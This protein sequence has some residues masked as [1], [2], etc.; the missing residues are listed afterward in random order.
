M[1]GWGRHV[2]GAAA[3]SYIALDYLRE[4]NPTLH[5]VSQPLLWGALAAAA[6]LRAPWYGHWPLELRAA[7]AFLACL[8]FMLCALCI[9][10]ISVQFVT[11]VLGLSWHWSTPPLPDTGQW[12]LLA[13]NE[14]L[15]AP[16]VYFLRAHLVILNHYLML[17]LM[18]AFSVVFDV[19]KA[20]GLGLGSRYMFTMAIGRL[21]RV[22]TFVATILPSAR[23]WCA[24]ARFRVPEYPHPWAQK[25][26]TPYAN[27]PNKIKALLRQDM[28]D[29]PLAEYP[30]EY[31][32]NW[33]F[34]Q[35]LVDFLRPIEPSGAEESWFHTL[36]RA[37]GG[38]ND[39]IFSGHILVSV[40]TAMAWTEANP[41]WTSWFVWICVLHSAQREIR[42][43]HHY[44]VDVV[45]GIYMGILLWRITGF[46]WSRKDKRKELKASCFLKVEGKFL[47]AAKD[48]DVERIRALL[49]ELE[50]AGKE[51]RVSRLALAV[52]GVV[53][54]TLSLSLGLLAFVWTVDG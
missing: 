13:F 54:I 44:S 36:K 32:P 16:L 10:A 4:T 31:V 19:V 26:Y 50:H 21:I 1:G 29:A 45:A 38:C 12:L 23:P 11:A 51:K 33:G 17:F 15:P 18:L 35:F 7:P 53:V 6:A 27:D 9:E 37:G 22:L 42:E 3:V 34:M 24:H 28:I 43:R 47:Q 41:G 30:P 52:F 40:L 49:D 46:L 14:H 8:L 2:L 48:G 5:N 20:P 25:F 39:L